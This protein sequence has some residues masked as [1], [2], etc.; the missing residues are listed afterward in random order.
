MDPQQ[1][2]TRLKALA[3]SLSPAQIASLL[4]AFVVVVGILVG[5]AYWA[6]TPTMALLVADM[7]PGAASSMVSRL[8]ALKVQYVL[9]QGG[10]AIR[11]PA[12]RVDEL[13]LEVASQGLPESGRIGFEIFDRTNFGATEFL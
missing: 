11:V 12:D 3:S 10:R 8:K 5:G 13:R 4:A 6:N 9:D 1:I 2:M 7:E